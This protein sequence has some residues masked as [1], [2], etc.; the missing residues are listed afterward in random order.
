MILA[1]KIIALRKKA[2]WSQEELA[3]QLQVSRQAVSKWESAA[4]IPDLDKIV[5]LSQI[6]G[7]ST[8]Y[9]LQDSMEEMPAGVQTPGT[10]EDYERSVSLEEVNTYLAKRPPFA[11]TLAFAIM[12]YVLCPVPVILLGGLQEEGFLGISENAAGSLGIIVLFVIVT[13][14]T[15]V[16]VSQCMKMSKYEYLEKEAFQLEYGGEGLVRKQKEAY[17]DTFRISIACGVGL[18]IGGVIPLFIARALEAPEIAYVICV[19]VL[20]CV[21]SA[22]VHLFVRAGI[23]W[24]TFEILLEEGDHTREDKE[25]EK[26]QMPG[27]FWCVTTAI[28]LA[29]SFLTGRW[30]QTW[31]IW[32]VAGC[33]FAALAGVW[34]SVHKKRK[35][36]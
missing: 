11:R 6:F 4:S 10:N 13:A 25:M 9:L 7:V 32:P 18:C 17:E 19:A 21:I 33:L 12:C 31:I 3:H 30:N 29:V 24:E 14:A 20:L 35:K 23:Q 36:A 26:S 34:K 22:A 16:V 5:K 15:V 8:D 2:G 27:I 28:Y 1:D